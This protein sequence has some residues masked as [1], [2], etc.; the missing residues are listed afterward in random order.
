MDTLLPGS[1]VESDG[2]SAGNV[3]FWARRVYLQ[4]QRVN[5]VALFHKFSSKVPVHEAIV[6][7]LA[8]ASW[9]SNL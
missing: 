8:V 1:M 9:I 6:D 7:M 2:T 4:C 5:A 3:A